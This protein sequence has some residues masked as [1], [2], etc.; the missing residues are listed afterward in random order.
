MAD[1]YNFG[2][3][4]PIVIQLREYDIDAPLQRVPI[5]IVE[6]AYKIVCEATGDDEGI[7]DVVTRSTTQN[8]PYTTYILVDGS[9][10]Y[11]G[12]APSEVHQKGMGDVIYTG[13]N[14]HTLDFNL[15][16]FTVTGYNPVFDE[17]VHPDPSGILTVYNYAGDAVDLTYIATINYNPSLI[18]ER[19]SGIINYAHDDTDHKY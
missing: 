2:A 19:G 5:P 15:F 16:S 10:K 14:D 6:T 7:A 11:D 12:A 13:T 17:V 18:G 9:F 3:E 4:G 1:Y 8:S